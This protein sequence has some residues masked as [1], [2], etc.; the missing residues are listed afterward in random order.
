MISRMRVGPRSHH[1]DA[2]GE[3]DRLLD[4]VRDEHHRLVLGGEHLQQQVLHRRAGLRIERAERLVHQQEL[5]LDRVGAR[6][7][8][9]LA[10]AARQHAR[11]GV[12]E[13]GEAHEPHVAVADL[14]ALGG[15][16]PGWRAG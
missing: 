14:L 12:G 5:R 3:V 7:G 1:D 13:V 16:A 9:A 8:E 6:Q 4:R 2:V 15:A 11:P 10:H